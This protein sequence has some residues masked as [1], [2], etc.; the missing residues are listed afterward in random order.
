MDIII[1]LILFFL[2][3]NILIDLILNGLGIMLIILKLKNLT[4]F[5]NFVADEE[6]IVGRSLTGEPDNEEIRFVMMSKNTYV[7]GTHKRS[8]ILIVDY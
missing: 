8:T 3:C 2:F 5:L 1:K 6:D 4:K 7:K